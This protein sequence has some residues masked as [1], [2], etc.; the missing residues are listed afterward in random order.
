MAWITLSAG[1]LWE[2]ILSAI[3]RW[4]TMFA[5]YG[6]HVEHPSSTPPPSLPA[7]PYPELLSGNANSEIVLPYLSQ[8]NCWSMCLIFFFC[9]RL[10]VLLPS[11]I[12]WT[13]W[14]GSLKPEGGDGGKK[15]PGEG[16]D[17][18][19]ETIQLLICFL[20]YCPSL[21]KHSYSQ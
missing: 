20:Q 16:G 7:S 18:L 12:L 14:Q 2:K 5:N 8:L 17:N 11:R 6:V 10:T 4:E 1:W 21:L 19:E 9:S 3:G 13:S 15:G